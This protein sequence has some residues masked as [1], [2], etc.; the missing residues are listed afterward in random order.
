MGP[1]LV[2]TRSLYQ[3]QKVRTCLTQFDITRLPT[4]SRIAPKA[5]RR[6]SPPHR[7][8]RNHSADNFG[9]ALM[10][11]AG[12]DPKGLKRFFA[13]LE[14]LAPDSETDSEWL[15]IHPLNKDRIDRSDAFIEENRY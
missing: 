2:L 12:Y 15:S 6:Q 11:N 7:R 14:D 3:S 5:T 9:F 10:S 1:H 4:A 8:N 13:T